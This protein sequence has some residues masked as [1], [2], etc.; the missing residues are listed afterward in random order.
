MPASTGPGPR[1]TRTHV[2]LQPMAQCFLG[3]SLLVVVEAEAGKVRMPAR[4]IV[5]HDLWIS[6]A[7]IL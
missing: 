2:H 1:A 4:V 3:A 7:K 6:M 5:I